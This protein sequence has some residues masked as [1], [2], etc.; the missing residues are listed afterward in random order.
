MPDRSRRARTISAALKM[1]RVSGA[2]PV[3]FSLGHGLPVSPAALRIRHFHAKWRAMRSCRPGPRFRSR[4]PS[5]GN[6]FPRP[7]R[8][9]SHLP[10]IGNAGRPFGSGRAFPTV[11]RSALVEGKPRKVRCHVL[12]HN[13]CGSSG[14][15]GASVASGPARAWQD[16]RIVAGLGGGF[17][18]VRWSRALRQHDPG[19]L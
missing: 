18:L 2:M 11:W 4:S 5:R 10:A 6:P 9:N 15:A 16:V 19:P 8:Q 12:F 1:R 17:Q 13:R 3:G 7:L 14:N